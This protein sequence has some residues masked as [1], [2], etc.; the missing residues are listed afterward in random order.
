VTWSTE[1]AS[2]VVPDV[3]PFGT[4]AFGTKAFGTKAFGTKAFGTK[5]FAESM[6][7]TGCTLDIAASVTAVASKI[8][9]ILVRRF[10][11]NVCMGIMLRCRFCSAKCGRL[12]RD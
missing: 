6:A 9:R 7:K 4:K 12:A 8:R 5:A 2:E 11:N 10:R 1:P 3:R